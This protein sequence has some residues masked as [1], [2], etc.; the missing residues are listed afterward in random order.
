MDNKLLSLIENAGCM[1]S[2]LPQV[3]TNIVE[4]SGDKSKKTSS[5]YDNKKGAVE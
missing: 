5:E 1:E 2:L 4:I 3:F